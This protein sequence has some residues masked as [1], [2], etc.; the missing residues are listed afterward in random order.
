[1][2]AHGLHNSLLRPP[3]LQILRAAGFHSTRPSV[4]DT[5][6]DLA[7]RY[8]DLLASTT[9]AQS[10]NHVHFPEPQLED[11]RVAMEECGVFR[12]QR[13]VAED[14]WQGEEDLRGLEAFLDWARGDVNQEI[15]RI[16]GMVGKPDAVNVE[17][18]VAGEDFL[19]ALKKRHSKTGDE[20]RYQGTVLGGTVDDRTI[21]IEGG[22]MSSIAEWAEHLTHQRH[23]DP[24]AASD[25][26]PMRAMSTSA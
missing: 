19:T 6:V 21:T 16:A 12:P 9:A 2:S 8:L 17:T 15:R 14:E 5:V 20:A 11:V 22:P 1:M 7:A 3:I 25:G 24:S 13:T 4:L 18:T 10:A 26:H 23:G